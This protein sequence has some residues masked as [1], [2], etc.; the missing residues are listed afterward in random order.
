MTLS[1]YNDRK[2]LNSIILIVPEQVTMEVDLVRLLVN[3]TVPLALFL[4]MLNSEP[5]V[6]GSD[7]AKRTRT[8]YV[9]LAGS[10]ALIAPQIFLEEINSN[11]EL[12]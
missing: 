9:L 1:I 4:L 3:F 8:P 10:L 11:F 12:N 7:I 2:S 6:R 5:Q